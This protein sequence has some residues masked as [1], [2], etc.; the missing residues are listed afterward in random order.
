MQIQKKLKYILY[1]FTFISFLFFAQSNAEEGEAGTE[2]NF[3]LGFGARALGLGNAFTALADDPTAVFWN[4]AGLEY[5]YQQSATL[6]H[7]SLWEGTN[8][9]FI[10]YAY[11][12]I[13]FGTFGIGIGRIG[14]GD[15]LQTDVSGT[16]SENKNTFTHEEIQVY[17]S[18]AKRLP[19]NMHITPGITIRYVRRGWSGLQGHLY[20]DEGC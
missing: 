8:Y 7:T 2:S 3:K 12:T 17:M 11:P 5:I 14:V 19:L 20:N 1:V 9:D 4:P 13:N 16:P 15:I 6:F 18:Y 10:G